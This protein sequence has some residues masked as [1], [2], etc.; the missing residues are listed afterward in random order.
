[1]LLYLLSIY[2][3]DV[4]DIDGRIFAVIVL[5][6]LFVSI[7]ELPAYRNEDPYSVMLKK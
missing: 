6:C 3:Y 2:N 1:M 7:N 4:F 5:F